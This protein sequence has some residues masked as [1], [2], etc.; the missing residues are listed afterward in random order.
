MKKLQ[1][2]QMIIL[3]ILGD[4]NKKIQPN[5]YETFKLTILNQYSHLKILKKGEKIIKHNIIIKGPAGGI[6]KLL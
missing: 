2:M 5:E 3:K 1:I 4:G 6:I